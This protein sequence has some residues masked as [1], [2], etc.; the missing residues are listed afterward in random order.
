MFFFCFFFNTIEKK[1]IEHQIG[2]EG[3]GSPDE[4]TNEQAKTLLYK[5]IKLENKKNGS[6]DP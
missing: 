5:Y 4:V 2:N 1:E 3:W 6:F